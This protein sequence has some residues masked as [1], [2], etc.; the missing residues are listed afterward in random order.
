ML[1]LLFGLGKA[2]VKANENG[3]G[4]DDLVLLV[5]LMNDI[6]P[7]I[8]GADDILLEMKDLDEA[9]VK[10]LAEIAKSELGEIFDDA[11]LMIKIEKGIIAGLAVY[12]LVKELMKKEEA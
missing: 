9:E 2:F 7:A 4:A 5:P 12:D 1:K 6:G 10:E 11:A 8:D 3:L